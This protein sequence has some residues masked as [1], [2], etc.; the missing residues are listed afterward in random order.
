MEALGTKYADHDSTESFL[1][2]GKE[3]S[4][5]VTYAAALRGRSLTQ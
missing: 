2:T 1:G 3:G 4:E 5:R